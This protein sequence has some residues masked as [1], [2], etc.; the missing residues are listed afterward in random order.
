MRLFCP[1]LFRGLPDGAVEEKA[2]LG[3]VV[4]FLEILSV[5]TRC[6]KRRG[7]ARVSIL[8]R[9]QLVLDLRDTLSCLYA[10]ADLAFILIIS[11]AIARFFVTWVVITRIT[12]AGVAIPWAV[13]A[14][15]CSACLVF[16]IVFI[17]VV[18][19]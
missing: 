9:L 1:P 10:N 5:K 19:T 16:D 8:P 17:K 14:V 7:G 15:I 4:L 6:I 2:I 3:A 18:K 11:V 12:I 13:L